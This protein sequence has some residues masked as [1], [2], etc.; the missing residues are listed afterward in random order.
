MVLAVAAD[1]RSSLRPA[2]RKR[3]FGGPR[4]DVVHSDT[5]IKLDQQRVSHRLSRVPPVNSSLLT[6][7]A[8]PVKHALYVVA[9]YTACGG[10]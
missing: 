10:S 9:E 4:R 5:M 3:G 8:L 1:D 2:A 7:G 6:A